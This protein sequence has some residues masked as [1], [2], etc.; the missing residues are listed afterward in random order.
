MTRDEAHEMAAELCGGDELAVPVILRLFGADPVDAARAKHLCKQFWPALL[1]EIPEG[2]LRLKRRLRCLW[3]GVKAAAEEMDRYGSGD[4]SDR[5]QT[6]IE[7]LDRRLRGGLRAGQ[8]T[9]LGAPT[10]SGKTTLVQQI[11]VAAARQRKGSV[12]IVS[13]EMSLES[14]AER[15]IVRQSRS[16]L[17]D[18]NPWVGVDDYA[19]QASERAHGIAMS[20]ILDERLPILVLEDLEVTMPIIES[21]AKEQGK[22]ALILIDYAQYVAGDSARQTPRYLQVGEVAERSVEMSIKLNVPVLVASQVNV[23]REGNKKAYTFRESQILE[24]KANTVLIMD[25]QWTTSETT[26]ERIVERTDIVCTKQR[27]A[28]TFTLKVHYEP[29]LYSISDEQSYGRPTTSSYPLLAP[30]A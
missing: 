13:P 7:R 8:M 9:L 4:F 17:F 29:H 2:Q 26:G 10:G 20:K 1:G 28:A 30:P 5:V 19:K 15:E 21:V 24:H 22:L 23:A 11:A 3:E 18:R 14:L 27:G 25:V 12:L 16:S 6:G